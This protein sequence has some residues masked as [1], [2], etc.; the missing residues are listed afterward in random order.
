MRKN[1][2]QNKARNEVPHPTK[3]E[4]GNRNATDYKPNATLNYLNVWEGRAADNPSIR[5]AAENLINATASCTKA[6]FTGGGEETADCA[7]LECPTAT[8]STSTNATTT[9]KP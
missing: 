4:S 1:N 6:N 2:P 5:E 8:G 3:P 7:D 9:G